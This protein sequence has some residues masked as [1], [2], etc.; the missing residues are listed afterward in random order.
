MAYRLLHSVTNSSITWGVIIA[1]T[2]ALTAFIYC[3]EGDYRKFVAPDIYVVL[4][5]ESFPERQ[6]FYTWVEGAVLAV[7]FE[8]LSES[9]EAHDWGD[10]I[11]Q[12]L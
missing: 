6:S 8:F 4:G 5:A 3:R 1:L 2:S 7:V 12:Y 11:R 10:K 9:T